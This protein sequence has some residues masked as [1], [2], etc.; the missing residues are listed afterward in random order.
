MIDFT[1]KTTYKSICYGY[2]EDFNN[3]SILLRDF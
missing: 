1:I 2:F 3:R